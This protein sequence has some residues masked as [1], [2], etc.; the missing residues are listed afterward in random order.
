FSETFLTRFWTDVL[1]AVSRGKIK[2]HFFDLRYVKA[3]KNGFL[4]EATDNKDA[5][6]VCYIAPKPVFD[7]YAQDLRSRGDEKLLDL[8][9]L[10]REM[11]KEPYW[12]PAPSA[13]PKVHRTTIYGSQQTCWV[14]SL[15]KKSDGT[16]VF[17][18]GEDFEQLLEPQ[19]KKGSS[20]EDSNK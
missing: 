1:S 19:G 16:Y 11:A 14:I 8:G 18:F 6:R 13:E 4:K 10:R 9:D 20:E 15:E 12:I 5:I 3:T 7:E 17:P 2:R